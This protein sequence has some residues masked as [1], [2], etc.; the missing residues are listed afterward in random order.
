MK[1]LLSF[2][3]VL[4]PAGTV[5]ASDIFRAAA[6]RV[7]ITP[8]TGLR[9]WG[10]SSRKKP[11]ETTL[12]PLFA[13]ILVLES[14][15]DRI[16]LVTLDLGRT[17]GLKSLDR[18]RSLVS[19]TAAVGQVFFLASHT[20][21]GPVIE[22][23][24]AGEAP[25]DWERRALEKIT[26]SIEKTVT[27]L[28][29]ARIGTGYG[30]AWIAHNRRRVLADGSVEMIW[31]NP[32]RTP[33]YPID[34][35]VGVIRIDDNEGSPLAVLVSFACHPVILGPDNLGYSS[36]FVGSMRRHVEE[37]LG[38][39]T[40]T[41]F[42]QGACGD[43]NPHFDKTP[44]QS[45]G[46]E[47]LEREGINLGDEV[48]RI[49]RSVA[50]KVPS[51]ASLKYRLTPLEFS[52]RW[53]LDKIGERLEKLVGPDRVDSYRSYFRGRIVC[54]VMTLIINREIAMMGMPGEPFVE[55]GLEFRARS[56]LKDAFLIG[57]ANGHYG[58]FPTIRAAVEGGYGADGVVTRVEVG[59]GERMLDT[60]IVALQEMLGELK[61][62][63]R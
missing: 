54:P 53:D 13:T 48:V 51:E 17:F 33:T 8:E 7:E 37:S 56:P 43:I 39:E 21:A 25:P 36:D 31:G 47:A 1:F 10:Y 52:Q 62:V 23:R 41:L 55:F 3:L 60:A 22:D 32:T 45:G 12:D 58:Y 30:E 49:A 38:A 28:T 29:P 24:S 6:D 19:M 44:L 59:A 35:R 40:V 20:H 63:P 14:G 57:Y 2:A 16:A 46:L 61:M 50:T 18:I 5:R 34:P 15:S 26:L 4:S 27:R 11:S 9:M 42:L